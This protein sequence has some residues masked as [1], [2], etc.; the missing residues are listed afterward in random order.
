MPEIILGT[1]PKRLR[2][3]KKMCNHLEVTPGYDPLTTFRGKSIVS[4]KEVE[5]CLSIL[6]APRPAFAS[7]AGENIVAKGAWTLL[8]QGWPKDDKDHPSDPAY[9]LSEAV[10]KH[11]AEVI[12]QPSDGTQRD[13]PLYLFGHDIGS[14]I[15]GEPVVRPPEEGASRLAMFYI[16]L[17]V[18]V[19]TD[20]R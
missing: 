16:P 4:A 20:N 17:I 7:Y 18:E 1:E 9:Y 13:D 15:I 12:R 10:H 2:I 19:T 5:D 6:E 11:L 14:M 8:L 3:L